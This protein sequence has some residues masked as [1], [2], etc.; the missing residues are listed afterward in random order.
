MVGATSLGE[1]M[2]EVPARGAIV[3]ALVEALR[4]G[5]AAEVVE[6]PPEGVEARAQALVQER[7]GAEEWTRER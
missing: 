5:W 3:E 7:Y 1:L 2:E 6:G 4:E